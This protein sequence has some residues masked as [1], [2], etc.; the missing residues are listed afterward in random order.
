M[1]RGV[2]KLVWKMASKSMNRLHL[3]VNSAGGTMKDG[4][5]CPAMT[6]R[7]LVQG[8]LECNAIQSNASKSHVNP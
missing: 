2:E 1:D 3:L 7:F 4:W 6:L 8:V 5:S